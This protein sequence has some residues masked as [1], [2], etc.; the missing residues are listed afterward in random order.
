MG[1]VYVCY[2]YFKSQRAE[3]DGTRACKNLSEITCLL[4]RRLG[5]ESFIEWKKNTLSV[6]LFFKYLSFCSGFFFCLACCISLSK[7]DN[8]FRGS[9]ANLFF[10][11]VFQCYP[12]RK[13][14]EKS[15]LLGSP[16]WGGLLLAR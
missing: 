1:I 16:S 6:S 11:E 12:Y 5:K 2:P 3:G 9:S 4:S 14:Y 8:P 10:I 15:A 7:N 13:L